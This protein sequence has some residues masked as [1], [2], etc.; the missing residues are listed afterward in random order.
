MSNTTQHNLADEII[1]ALNVAKRSK[2]FT[3]DHTKGDPYF[4]LRGKYIDIEFDLCDEE[5]VV[6][7]KQTDP[8]IFDTLQEEM[9]SAKVLEG[10]LSS[11]MSNLIRKFYSK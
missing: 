6:T 10:L 3:L 1:H 5:V 2:V 4:F 11:V 9:E 8:V 7:T